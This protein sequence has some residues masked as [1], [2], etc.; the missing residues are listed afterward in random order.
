VLLSGQ[1]HRRK[2]QDAACGDLKSFCHRLPPI[3][4]L[5]RAPSNSLETRPA[6][7]RFAAVPAPD[8]M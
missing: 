1:Q 4:L 2:P 6:C 7:L 5:K 8:G 3:C